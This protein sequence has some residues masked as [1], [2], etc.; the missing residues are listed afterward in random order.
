MIT[1]KKNVKIEYIKILSSNN[2]IYTF[3]V[4][5]IFQNKWKNILQLDLNEK[6]KLNFRTS[7]ED[8][9]INI[10]INDNTISNEY[11]FN[12][13]TNHYYIIPINI[14]NENDAI[15]KNK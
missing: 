3:Y 13:S 14:I 1:F 6:N 9:N 2:V 10:I 8:K 7:E 4:K 12:L 11:R 15:E 5:N